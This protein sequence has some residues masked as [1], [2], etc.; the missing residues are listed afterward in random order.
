MRPWAKSLWAGIQFVA[1]SIV[2]LACWALWLALGGLF[3]LQ[4]R[5]AF[6]S[7]LAVPGFVLRS[8]E[9]RFTASHVQVRFGRATFDATGNI[10]LEKVTLSL[11]EFNEPVAT[12]RAVLVEL[13]P[14][15]L[16]VGQLE[17]HR[18]HATGIT[19]SVPAMLTPSGRT[20]NTLNEIDFTVVPRRNQLDIEH[21]TARIAGVALEVHG[22]FHLPPR[23]NPGPI[24]PLPL[25]ES[26]AQHYVGFCRQ[27]IR[28]AAELAPFEQ[29][30]LRANLTPSATRGA[31]ADV[32]LTASHV[33]LAASSNVDARNLDV[34]IRVPLLGDGDADA[35]VAFG[36]EEV[37][38]ANGINLRDVRGNVRGSVNPAKFSYAL[39]EVEVGATR[40]SARGFTVDSLSA[41]LRSPTRAVWDA[42]VTTA[43]LGLPLDM[44][45]HVDLTVQKAQLELI[46]L[47]APGLLEPISAQIGH[48][49]RRFIGFGEPLWVNLR[50]TFGEG[51][52]FERVAGRI[53]AKKVDA[54]HVPID[55]A[56]GEIEFDGRHFLAQHATA[57]LGQNQA[58]GSF[59]QDLSD[60]RFRFLLEGHLRPLE[61]GGWFGP[62]WPDFFQHFE[63]PAAPPK[64]SVDVSGR[65]LAGGQTTVFVFAES[66]SPTIRGTAL[67]YGRTIMFIRPNF[68]DAL[69]FFGTH[70]AGDV[71]GSFTRTID[72]AQH[73]WSGMTFAVD[74]TIDLPTGSGLLGEAFASRLAPFTFANP[75]QVIASGHLE[76][77]AA[78]GG[79]HQTIDIKAQS[80]G[81]FTVYA[82]PARNVSFEAKLRDDE[83][84]LEQVEAEVASGTVTGTAR[85]FG[86]D[87]KRKLGFDLTVKGGLLSEAITTVSNY[88]AQ[89][90]GQPAA[91]EDKI[92][93]G[94][95]PIKFDANVTAEGRFD[96]LLSYQGKGTAVLNGAELGEVR[97]LGLLSALLDFTALRFTTAR[98]NFQLQGRKVFF[99]S[100]SITGANSSV[101]GHG[102]Y[103]LDRS[104]I[105][106]NARV[107]PFG[108]S[109]SLLQSVVGVVLTPLSA[110]L[111]VKLTGALTQPSWAFVIGPTNF[112]R[113][114]TQSPKTEPEATPPVDTPTPVLKP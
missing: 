42:T 98:L 88:A 13:D 92:L 94:K 54:Y 27:L 58:Q 110:A 10:L 26:L 97:L 107:F 76:G 66:T 48:D 106:F 77:P 90:R 15:L 75:P 85:V 16:M 72:L 103:W 114:L 65:W 78:P 79:E 93:S 7:E 87:G 84:T 86:P 113:S 14:W 99:P 11:P 62:W 8:L 71:R 55:A 5:I 38:A 9:E 111:E 70:G 31:L 12:V 30:T 100:V 20:E 45:A 28:V 25:I 112:I 74:S 109:K 44:A 2:L 53:A 34:S 81:G 83:L 50:T 22:G 57:T 18:V 73:D 17:A 32:T 102:D 68:F 60:L 52:K 37:Q 80:T 19:L 63:F 64:A 24:A 51:W 56:D 104:E 36:V 21:L 40:V 3:A 108:E 96:D 61:I 59:E 4:L 101:E 89:R 95:S 6:S 41:I 49:V 46:G 82:F 67:D 47:L 91:S 29:P 39:H 33:R 23:K 35:P 1:D 43:C 105:E 69:E